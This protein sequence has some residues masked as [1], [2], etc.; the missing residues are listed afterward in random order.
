ME[1]IVETHKEG[2]TMVIQQVFFALQQPS[3]AAICHCYQLC[4]NGLAFF[5]LYGVM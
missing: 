1:S 3:N 4:F 5:I 2:V